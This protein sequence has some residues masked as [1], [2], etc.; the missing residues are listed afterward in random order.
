MAVLDSGISENVLKSTAGDLQ[1]RE[2]VNFTNE[3]ETHD[4]LGHGT[5]IAG[6]VASQNPDCPGLAPDAHLYVLKLFTAHQVTYSSWF[7]DAFNFVLENDIDLVNLSNG[8][9]DFLDLPFVE[10]IEE[11]TAKGVIVV[12]A[13]GNEGPFQGTLNNPG[14]LVNVI[15][16]GSLDQTLQNVAVYSSRGIAT[17][18]LLQGAGVMKPDLLTSGAALKGLSIEGNGH[19]TVQSGTSVSASVLTGS[20]ALALSA[21]KSDQERK[22]V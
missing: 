12:G 15:G 13:I 21:I 20:L 17:W 11:L 5:F 9:S 6:M 22:L 16:V 3:P 8:S 7:L 10:K 4:T 2:L 1:V 19:C 14:D 18:A